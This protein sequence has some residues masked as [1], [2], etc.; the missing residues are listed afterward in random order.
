MQENESSEMVKV[1][2]L[3]DNE[4]QENKS[5][6]LVAKEEPSLGEHEKAEHIIVD[7]KKI[8]EDAETQVTECMLILND[9]LK[10]F[11]ESKKSLKEKSLE[12][13]ETLLKK[14]GFNSDM[15][16]EDK[17]EKV[18]F[19]YKEQDKIEKIDI[20]NVSSGKFSSFILSLIIGAITI[21]GLLFFASSALKIDFDINKVQDIGYLEPLLVWI[22]QLF[23]AGANMMMGLGVLAVITFLVMYIIYKIRVSLKASHNLRE[24]KDSHEQA[25]FYCTK[26]DECKKEIERVDAH[27]TEVVKTLDVYSVFLDEQNSK[28]QRILFIEDKQDDFDS[29][30]YKSQMIIEATQILVDSI[31]NMLSVPMSKGGMLSIESEEALFQTKTALNIFA[32]KTYDKS[33]EDIL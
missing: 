11:K 10:S 18:E 1:V 33:I 12:K 28:L 25:E 19:G 6:T 8:I 13:S 32:Q 23:T 24:A 7:A 15:I 29:Y 21:I 16:S 22:G 14:L 17:N 9:D 3:V 30:H 31:N 2:D 20:K 27:I 4:S 5:T 26:K